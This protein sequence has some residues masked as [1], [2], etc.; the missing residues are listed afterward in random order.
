M[1]HQGCDVSEGNG[2]INTS[3]LHLVLV[4]ARWFCGPIVGHTPSHVRMRDPGIY[5]GMVQAQRSATVRGGV[6][7][8]AQRAVIPVDALLTLREITI[9]PSAEPVEVASLGPRIAKE[10]ETAYAAHL[11]MLAG[12]RREMTAAA[13]PRIILGDS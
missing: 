2:A 10:I 1:V 5:V 7:V 8:Q 12:L 4:G 6:D 11:D 13:V 9:Y 3:A